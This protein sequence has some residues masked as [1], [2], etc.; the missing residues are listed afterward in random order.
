M[1]IVRCD[2]KSRLKRIADEVVIYAAKS[3]EFDVFL[4]ISLRETIYKKKLHVQL[5]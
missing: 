4:H 5:A 2:L 1:T 3:V